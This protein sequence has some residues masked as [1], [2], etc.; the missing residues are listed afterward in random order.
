MLRRIHAVVGFALPLAFVLTG[1][2]SDSADDDGS[3]GSSMAGSGGTAGS[4]GTGGAGKGGSAGGGAAAGKGGGSGK[5]GGAGAGGSAG[6]SAGAGA[7]GTAGEGNAGAGTSGAGAAAGEGGTSG[8]AAG[9]G[10]DAGAGGS[11]MSGDAY[12]S[13]VEIVVHDEVNTILVVTWTQVTAADEVF[14]EFTFEEGNVMRSRPKPGTAGE[15]R[16]VV[17]GVPGD[18][19][20]T[21]R[22]VSSLAGT[23]HPTTDYTGTTLAVPS[24]MPEPTV[25]E[26]DASIAS[27]DRFMFGAVEDSDGGCNNQSCF[28]H[29]TFWVYIMDR[30][31]RIVWYYADP[32]SNA[33]SSFQRIARDGEYIWIEKRPFSGGGTRGVLKMTLD[34]EYS[35]E[36]PVPS[37]SDCIDVTDDGSLLFDT[38]SNPHL[39]REMTADGTFR[40][41]WDCTDHFA[42]GFTCYSNTVNWNELDDTVLMSFPFEKTVIEVDRQTGD[43][44]GQY[45]AAPGS[46]AFSPATWEFEFQHFANITPQGTLLVSSH[47]PGY[48]ETESPV[49]GQHAFMEFTIDRE[50]ETLEELWY[51]NEGDE[52]AMYKGMAIR[53]PN[54]NTLGNYGTGGVIRE[55]TPDKESAFVVKFDVPSGNDFFNKMVGHNVLI[56]DLYALNGGGPE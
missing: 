56:D 5:G 3:G 48:S 28:Y 25:L 41:I 16:D 50:N 44:V 1:C 12:V 13:D 2:G 27:P 53:L 23:E 21:V 39:L 42:Q 54:G 20:V 52:W 35:E 36:I 19:E 17:L 46:Y 43:V 30:Q 55:V 37:L 11:D 34:W 14:L 7:G 18:T 10:G 29:T 38:N 47:M 24:G 51:Y 4:A 8:A 40:T 49:A 6:A 15:H 32:A 31:G 33:T 26:Y 45:G 22:I 9:M